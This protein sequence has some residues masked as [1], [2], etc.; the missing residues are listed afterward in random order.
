[1]STVNLRFLGSG[2]AFGSGG[3]LQTCIYAAAGADHFLLDCGASSMIAMRRWA[4]DPTLLN[5]I[6]LTH[7]HGDHFGGLPFFLLDAQLVS[8]RTRPLIVAGPPGTQARI[9]AAQDALFPGASQVQPRFPLTYIEWLHGQSTPVGGLFVT[10]YE[11]VHASG[12]PPFALRVECGGKVL[13]YSGDTEWTDALM[14]AAQGADLF[15]CE[16]YYYDKKVKYHLDYGTLIAHRA[17]LGCKRL[18][19]THMSDDL[20]G[21][22]ENV[23]VEVAEDGKHI[24][25]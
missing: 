2:D 21:Q 5:I 23:D 3:R 12:A 17:V 1:M 19:L 6:L 4:V 20:L 18:I 11:V 25:L 10:P 13:A 14:Q 15:I 7:L 16:A 24:T 8:K 9:R 22:L